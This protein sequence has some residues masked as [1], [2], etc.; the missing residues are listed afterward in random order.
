MPVTRAD[1]SSRAPDAFAKRTSASATSAARSDT[2][3]TRPP[4]SVLSGTPSDS[5]NAIASAGE[6]ALAA[7]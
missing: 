4:R 6:K 1:A 5:K 7:P 2:G 3:N